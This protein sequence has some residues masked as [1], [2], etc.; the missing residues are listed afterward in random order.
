MPVRFLKWLDIG[1]K[2]NGFF[3]EWCPEA[4]RMVPQLTY[5]TIGFLTIQ[6]LTKL[7][8]LE[9]LAIGF[10]K[11]VGQ[12]PKS[13]RDMCSDRPQGVQAVRPKVLLRV[14]KT[15]KHVSRACDGSMCAKGV[16]NRIK[17][18]SLLKSRKLV[19]VLKAQ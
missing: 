19:K 8:C 7:G 11:K 3:Q 9:P 13:S 17:E 2:S 10:A 12:A 6:P 4:L 15:K 18:L 1:Y 5:H 14:P 16:H